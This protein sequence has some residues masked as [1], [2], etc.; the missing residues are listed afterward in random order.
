MIE[1]ARVG[2]VGRFHSSHAGGAQGVVRGPSNLRL[3]RDRTTPTPFRVA[4]QPGVMARHHGGAG[5][6]EPARGGAAVRARLIAPPLLNPV[7]R[8]LYSLMSAVHA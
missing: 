3:A 4:R 5:S 1:F 8:P 7:L 2:M 6:G